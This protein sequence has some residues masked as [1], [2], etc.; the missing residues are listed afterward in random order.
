[1]LRINA[2]V[3]GMSV[4]PATPSSARVMMSVDAVDANA[5]TADAAPNAVAPIMRSF[6]RPIR[7]P[8]VPI[9][10]SELAM[11]KP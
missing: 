3:E 5:A 10:M 8:S 7:S 4:A 2:I 1:M 11:K 9:V 6:R